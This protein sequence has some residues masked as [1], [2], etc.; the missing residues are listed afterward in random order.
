MHITA[1]L[2][3]FV[4]DCRSAGRRF[5]ASLSTCSSA[6][7]E[8]AMVSRTIGLSYGDKERILST[9]VKIIADMGN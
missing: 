8:I 7:F 3:G 5:L 6:F 1:L 9:A 4:Q 2:V